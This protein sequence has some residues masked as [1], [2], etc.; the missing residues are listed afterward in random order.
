MKKN[1]LFSIGFLLL[2]T[3]VCSCSDD[4]SVALQSDSNLGIK[5]MLDKFYGSPNGSTRSTVANIQIDGI[6]RQTYEVQGDSAIKVNAEAR[7]QTAQ[8]GAIGDGTETVTVGE[9]GLPTMHY[10]KM[11]HSIE[12]IP[13]T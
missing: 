6:E 4:Q 7:T 5:Q 9:M 12:N 13:I 3:F 2:T 1:F 8:N 10:R 11:E